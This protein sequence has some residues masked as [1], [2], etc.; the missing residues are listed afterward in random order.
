[1]NKNKP[2]YLV[3]IYPGNFEFAS[4]LF[5]ITSSTLEP[6]QITVKLLNTSV[7]CRQRR[8]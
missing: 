7:W 1:M 3:L 4:S 8:F 6:T 2:P 5:L